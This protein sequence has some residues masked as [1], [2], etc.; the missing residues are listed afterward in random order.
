MSDIEILNSGELMVSQ[1][2]GMT[3]AGVEFIDAFMPPEGA[4]I[5][6]VDSGRIILPNAYIDNFVSACQ[7]QGLTIERTEGI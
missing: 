6:V 4:E 1:A 5:A 7:K 2:S 3:D